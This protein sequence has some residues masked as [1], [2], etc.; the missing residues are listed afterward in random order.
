M[1]KHTYTIAV[2]FDNTLFKTEALKVIEPI[3]KTIDYCK[4]AKEKGH[5]L[6]LWTCRS[7]IALADAVY[8]C[9]KVGLTF[10]YVNAN[11]K[12]NLEAYGNID[13]RKIWADLYIDDHAIR[14]SELPKID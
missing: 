14:P 1:S 6:I 7:G 2:D 9:L 3:Q 4:R 10:D 5:T 11:T 8:E 12:E 13:T